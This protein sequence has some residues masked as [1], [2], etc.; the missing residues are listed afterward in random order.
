[1]EAVQLF[2]IYRVCN[3]KASQ[4]TMRRIMTTLVYFY[5]AHSGFD[6]IQKEGDGFLS[7]LAH[8]GTFCWEGHGPQYGK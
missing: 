4:I 6:W 8:I 3:L 2:Q 7:H 5:V 1:M